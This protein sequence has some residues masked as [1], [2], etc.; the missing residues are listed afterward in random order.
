MISSFQSP[1][2]RVK[3]CYINNPDLDEPI[4]HLSVPF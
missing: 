3:D 4:L 1:F 2:N